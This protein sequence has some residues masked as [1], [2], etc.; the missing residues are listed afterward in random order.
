MSTVVIPFPSLEITHQLLIAL[1][2]MKGKK[3]TPKNYSWMVF[4]THY[5]C[6]SNL[7]YCH[8]HVCPDIG[9]KI[10]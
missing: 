5:Y 7:V 4:K 2:E 6:V 10:G 8:E 1:N 3:L 9:R